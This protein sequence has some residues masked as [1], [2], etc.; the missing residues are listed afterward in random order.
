MQL[1][2]CLQDFKSPLL[3][4]IKAAENQNKIKHLKQSKREFFESKE[5]CRVVQ[6]LRKLSPWL[7]DLKMKKYDQ[8]DRNRKCL[9]YS[10]KG[11][12]DMIKE[13]TLQ[14]TD[15]GNLSYKT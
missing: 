12:K 7:L 10:E 5:N 15:K 11:D 9:D 6:Y 1:K 13:Q 8:Y 2:K 14:K 3:S 4:K